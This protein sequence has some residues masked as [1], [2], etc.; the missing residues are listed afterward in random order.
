MSS[1]LFPSAFAACT[2]DSAQ[3]RA[4]FLYRRLTRLRVSD[5][6]S[7]RQ[8]SGSPLAYLKSSRRTLLPSAMRLV[9]PPA[10]GTFTHKKIP[11]LNTLKEKPPYPKADR[12]VLTHRGHQ[13]LFI[14]AS[15]ITSPNITS[16]DEKL[17]FCY[18]QSDALQFCCKL[19]AILY[20]Q[21]RS[22]VCL[23]HKNSNWFQ[24]QSRKAPSP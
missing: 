10:L 5:A 24:T 16:F 17:N 6:A 12:P 22:L 7:V 3:S 2:S 20:H 18:L 21:V 13:R 11:M 19:L 8:L 14:K 23:I 9:L 4:F 1:V 15:E